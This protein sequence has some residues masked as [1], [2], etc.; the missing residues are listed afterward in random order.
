MTFTLAYPPSANRYWRVA[1]NRIYV[2]A[3]A[4]AYRSQ[5]ALEASEQGVTPLDGALIL[6][7]DVY[8]PRRVGD[9]SNRIKI[10]EDALNGVAWH[11]D[12]QIVELH[13]RRFEQAKQRGVKRFG[14]VVCRVEQAS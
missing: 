4:K 2:S 3:E 9:L 11:D 7:L 5:A 1:R 12:A 14:C 13:V 10:V 6:H 8:M